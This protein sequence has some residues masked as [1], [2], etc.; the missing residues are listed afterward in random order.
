MGVNIKTSW[1]QRKGPTVFASP[2]RPPP[3]LSDAHSRYVHRPIGRSGFPLQ[4]GGVK[5]PETVITPP[6][7]QRLYLPDRTVWF[8]YARGGVKAPETASTSPPCTNGYSYRGDHSGR[9]LNTAPNISKRQSRR[10]ATNAER[11]QPISQ[12]I[13]QHKSSVRH[14]Y[15][16]SKR[17]KIRAR[18]WSVCTLAWCCQLPGMCQVVEKKGGDFFSTFSLSFDMCKP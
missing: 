3:K 9:T 8:S 17:E 14:K 6:P 18:L 13:L 15:P 12:L 2:P 10:S 1:R 16:P 5:T 11:N 4:G 7:Y